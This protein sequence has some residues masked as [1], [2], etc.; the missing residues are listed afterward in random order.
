[1]PFLIPLVLQVS[2]GYSPLEAGM[3]VTC[4][5]RRRILGT[6]RFVMLLVQR[7]GYRRVLI[8]NTLSIGITMLCFGLFF[9]E[10]PMAIKV[11]LLVVLGAQNFAAVFGDEHDRAEGP[12]AWPGERR[13]Q[14]VVDDA[15]ARDE[16]GRHRRRRAARNLQRHFRPLDYV[17]NAIVVSRDAGLHRYLTAASA[18]IFW[19]LD[20]DAPVR[21]PPAPPPPPPAPPAADARNDG[22]QPPVVVAAHH[23]QHD[24]GGERRSASSAGYT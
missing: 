8:Q 23:L 3:M 16:P 9:A 1:M 5:F 19:Q 12:G 20:P 15:D 4:P 6:K 10:A 21:P 14:L 17:R 11:V 2:L 13:Q 24:P 22:V 18:W 7:F